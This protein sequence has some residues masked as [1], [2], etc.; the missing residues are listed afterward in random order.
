MNS[1]DN[2][3][4]QDGKNN[5]QTNN[6]TN[7]YN[8]INNGGFSTLLGSNIVFDHNAL[9]GIIILVHE[10]I[11]GDDNSLENDFSSVDINKK[12]EINNHSK[13][14]FR[15]VVEE[16]FYPYFSQLEKFIQLKENK[17]LQVRLES[18]IKDLNRRILALQEDKEIKFE[19]ILLNISNSIIQNNYDSM[20]DKES[21]I[22]LLLYYCYTTCSIGKK[23]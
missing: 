23:K 20:S 7:N 12:N 3:I 17:E 2:T 1:P 9:K 10:N 14:Y 18:I 13:S 4:E 11:S 6:I 21:Q 22:L 19:Q 5:T 16:D 8:P 15:N